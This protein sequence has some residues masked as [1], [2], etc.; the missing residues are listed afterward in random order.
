MKNCILYT[1]SVLLAITIAHGFELPPQM[2]NAMA[3]DSWGTQFEPAYTKEEMNAYL[4]N[5]WRDIAADV[6]S[7]PVTKFYPKYNVKQALGSFTIFFRA[8]EELEPLE[9]LDFLDQMLIAYEKK[10]ISDLAFQDLIFAETKKQ[11]FL[12]VNYKYPRVATFLRKAVALIP[13]EDESL[14][15]CLED[16][17]N[18][19]L[20]DDY[21]VNRSDD[22]P[23]PQTLPGIK[24]KRPWDSLIRKYEKATGKKLPPDPDF[25]DEDVDRPNR[26]PD[27]INSDGDKYAGVFATDS[28][29]RIIYWI[30]LPL[31]TLFGFLVW[32]KMKGARVRRQPKI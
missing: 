6:E 14:R 10:Q 20:A 15:S 29:A 16:M 32:L 21:M 4:L 19:T 22:G 23:K 31:V 25:P 30:G 9:Y 17:A 28:A 1:T 18:G 13:E 27:L 12:S 11:D 7:L 5:N 3:N 2:V 24:L 8:C 26:R